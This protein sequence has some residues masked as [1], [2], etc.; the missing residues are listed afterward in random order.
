MPTK[1]FILYAQK[2]RSGLAPAKGLSLKEWEADSDKRECWCE[3]ERGSSLFPLFLLSLLFSLSP[4][5]K[6]MYEHGL[7]PIGRLG[8]H[9]H[10]KKINAHVQQEIGPVRI[11]W[12]RERKGGKGL[13]E[14][15]AG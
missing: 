1:R 12:G 3:V 9:S 2:Q 5:K 6:F 4:S 13:V 8:K 10:S 14:E 11:W 15:A 7:P